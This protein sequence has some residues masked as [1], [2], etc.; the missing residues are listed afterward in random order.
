MY[1][2]NKKRR[3]VGVFLPGKGS[4]L[5]VIHARYWLSVDEGLDEFLL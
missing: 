1:M 5:D 2:S 3:L 4:L